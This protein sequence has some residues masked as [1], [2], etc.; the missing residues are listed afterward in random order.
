MLFR[1]KI[2]AKIGSKTVLVP[3]DDVL[4]F[5]SQDH[6]TTLVTHGKEYIIDLSLGHL[7]KR[8]DPAK[9]QRLHRNNIVALDHI[10]AVHA[11]DN[12]QVELRGGQRFL[13]SRN[14][15]KKVKL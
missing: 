5:V 11:G 14:N 9:F 15:R 2:C 4:A 6:Y 7:E 8:L 10:Q 12:M 13:V 1:S 3:A